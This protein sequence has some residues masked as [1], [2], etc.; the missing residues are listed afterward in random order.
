MRRKYW[1]YDVSSGD[2]EGKE[3]IWLWTVDEEGA[4]HII[5][6]PNFKNY[7]YVDA[8]D[9][10]LG[11]LKLNLA[12]HISGA[13]LLEIRNVVK[14]FYGVERRFYELSGPNEHIKE[15]IQV[16]RRIYGEEKLFEDDIRF[17]NKYILVKGLNPCTWYEFEVE[18]LYER[19]GVVFE[20][21]TGFHGESHQM[22][23]PPLKILSIDM[24][25]ASKYGA[26]DPKKDPVLYI[27]VYD[28]KEFREFLYE[29]SDKE[30]LKEF[31]S[32]VDQLSP[33]I[34]LTFN[35]NG[36]IWPYLIERTR[37][38]G[39]PLTIGMLGIDIH[40]S[41]YGHTSIAGRVHVDLKEYAEDLPMLQR[42]TLE[43]LATFLGFEVEA[44][45]VDELQYYY[46]WIN[47]RKRL[48][49][50]VKWRAYILYKAFHIIRDQLFSLS[51]ITGIPPDYVFTASSGRQA[52]Y[53]IMRK[54]IEYN[55]VIPKVSQRGFR[56]YPG[57]LVLKPVKGLHRD[58]AVI[59]YKSMYPTIIMKNNISPETV[60]TSPGP[61]II[62]YDE[63]SIGVKTD[64]KGLFP[65]ILDHLVEE[66]D[67]VRRLMAS[68]D[69]ETVEYRVLD[70][71][72]RV[73]KILAN[74]LYGYMGWLG[75][76][77][78]SWEGASLVTY[79]GRRVISRS[80]RKAEEIG[81]KVIYGDTDSLFTVYD[82]DKVDDLLRWIREELGLEAKIDKIYKRLLFTEAKKRYAGITYDGIVDVVGL[83]YV[84]RD[85]CDYARETQ[86]ILIK[87]ILEDASKDKM[88]DV[89]R[90]R[91][92]RLRKREV[93][94]SELVIWE[95]I[96]RPLE[97]YKAN[98]PHIAV[99]RR[100]AAE[101]WRVKRGMFIGYII[102]SGEGPL[103]KRAVHYLEADPKEID[104]EYYIYN[105][106][107]PVAKRVLEPVGVSQ[108]TLESIASS[109]GFGLDAF[110]GG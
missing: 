87:M 91:I 2:Y 75:A 82:R 79:L 47:D 7:F 15:A 107:L 57:G 44:Q 27:V 105:Q 32:T 38:L 19:N 88:I 103:Y 99:A 17:T 14:K 20:L 73:L 11:D 35:G 98:A 6:D 22:T 68:M 78:Y 60:V 23:Y 9:I 16:L 62:F 39:S 50:Y 45:P 13:S 81:L 61:N 95:Q 64:V 43:E 4:Y 66:R 101:G 12:S 65:Q 84:R 104:V 49:E 8:E 51:S 30:I 83:E 80:L 25:I 31:D 94:I 26:P 97:E 55:E 3:V 53:Y 72:Q 37:H 58:I 67:R 86:Y 46:Y 59:D 100:L 85:W 48:I 69:R 102:L 10:D 36:F 42:K 71:R 1:F 52:E 74:T 92:R 29:G 76:R 28:G 77:W 110:T 56:S 33:H 41:L 70:A 106:V 34:I 90:D 89:L 21:L 24:V 93:P 40:Q 108:K 96:T 109:S 18:P 5:V 63:L 54:A